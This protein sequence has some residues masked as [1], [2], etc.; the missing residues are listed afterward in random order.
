MSVLPE[1]SRRKRR[2]NAM[3]CNG[4][5]I[6]YTENVLFFFCYLGVENTEINLNIRSVVSQ[7]DRHR[8]VFCYVT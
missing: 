7:S 3:Q 4:V 6:W 5:G 1:L 8:V 2:P